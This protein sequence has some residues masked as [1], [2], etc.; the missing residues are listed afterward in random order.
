MYGE[1]L[2]AGESARMR[3]APRS[4]P[5]R[6]CDDE[7]RDASLAAHKTNDTKKPLGDTR[8]KRKIDKLAGARSRRPPDKPPMRARAADEIFGTTKATVRGL[9]SRKTEPEATG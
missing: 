5:T 8:T 6:L 2:A 3:R 4:M 1:A 9:D 7:P